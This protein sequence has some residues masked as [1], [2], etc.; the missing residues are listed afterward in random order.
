MGAI[1]QKFIPPRL[2]WLLWGPK[3]QQAN[4]LGNTYWYIHRGFYMS[5]PEKKCRNWS[6]NLSWV[7]AGHMTVGVHSYYPGSKSMG[8]RGWKFAGK[9]FR[10]EPSPHLPVHTQRHLKHS[11]SLAQKPQPVSEGGSN[12]DLWPA[13]CLQ[14]TQEN[15]SAPSCRAVDFTL[16]ARGIV[17]T[18][19]FRSTYSEYPSPFWHLFL[20]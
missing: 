9:V 2:M 17:V 3:C 14:R 8:K 11:R 16:V 10:W 20:S 6:W 12:L 15:K 7:W 13:S 1:S 19:V 18:F 5:S 4:P